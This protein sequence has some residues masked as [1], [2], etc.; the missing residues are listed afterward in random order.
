MLKVERVIDLQALEKLL[1]EWEAIDAE[2]SPRTPFTTPSWN[3]AW[4][5]HM[6][7][8][9]LL[10]R[11]TFFAHAVNDSD[12]KVLAIAPMMITH[13]PSRGPLRLRGLGFFG[14]D[15]NLMTEIRGLVCRPA[16]QH[17]V[18][19]ALSKHFGAMSNEWDWI[20]WSWLNQGIDGFY[21]IDE[22]I[23]LER[24]RDKPDY[25]LS[26]PG[27]WD[28]FKSNLPRNIKESLR[29]CYNSL[30]RDGHAFTFQVLDRPEDIIAALQRLFNL[31]AARAQQKGTVWHRDV[32]KSPKSQLFLTDY[33]CGMAKRG[34]LRI[35]EIEIGGAVVATRLGF[36]LGKE[37]YIYY[38]GYHPNWGKY[39]IMTTLVAE[40]IKWAI[41]NRF[42]IFNLSTGTDFSKTR[43]RPKKVTYRQA[44]QLSSNQYIQLIHNAYS[45]ID[46]LGR[47]E[48]LDRL[49]TFL[50]SGDV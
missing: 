15:P 46:S 45:K 14:A 35:F 5:K 8:D 42:E 39:S 37:L 11:D 1:P 33:A 21:A 18:I 41:L 19:A 23:S 30:K 31:H 34:C 10:V 28:E 17:R 49:S 50:R 47:N 44:T 26:L 9:T 13:R 3:I 32:F 43:W 24:F 20:G 27:T 40:A 25:Y 38:G 2:L 16:D 6:R 22:F 7:S 48:R 4:W 36:V 29:K 12:S